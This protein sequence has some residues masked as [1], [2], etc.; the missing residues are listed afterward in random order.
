MDIENPE[1]EREFD[2]NLVER[3]LAAWRPATGALDRDRM[4]YD[5]GRAAA[6]T[7]GQV[8]PWRLAMASLALLTVGLSGLLAHE[9]SRCTALESS[10]AIASRINPPQPAG[11]IE[12]S[13]AGK[14]PAVEPFEPSS[15]FALTAR[16]ARGNS[17]ATSP[18]VEFELEH[19]RPAGGRLELFP[20]QQ[21][22]QPRDLHRVLDL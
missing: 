17:G 3:R 15:Y 12:L 9:R 14:T 7:D 21:P 8:W 10:L 2:M 4:L 11:T 20:R 1:I 19:R 18:D 13:A 22:L 5:A 16:L 6:R